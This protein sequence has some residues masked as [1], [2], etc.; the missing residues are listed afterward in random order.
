MNKLINHIPERIFT[1]GCSFTNY[2]WPTWANILAYDLDIPLYNYGRSGAG[3]QFIF[4]SLMQADYYHNFNKDDLVIICWTNVCR[5]DRRIK[6]QWV[7]NGNIWTNPYYDDKYLKKYADALGY[8]ARD[9]ASIKASWEILDKRKVK[10][11]FLKMLDFEY[12]DQ[13][14]LTEKF[15]NTD[16]LLKIYSVYLDK[17]H[18]SF[19]EILWSNDL[20]K[21][22][23]LDFEN[24]D[25]QF[26]DG[27]PT[28]IE[29]Y[30][31]LKEIFDHKFNRQTK[32]IV[33]K[34]QEDLITSI[35]KQLLKKIKPHEMDFKKIFFKTSESIKMF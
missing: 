21:K 4:N 3:N 2:K 23:Q 29:H 12:A 9:F 25:D 8:A 7:T 1:F 26:I 11:H 31:Y 34:T 18:K 16:E 28:V 17:I 20:D 32:D 5:E 14:S 6:N 24:I 27:H 13:W 15:K 35:K 33:H 22:R 10:F 19:Y 30:A